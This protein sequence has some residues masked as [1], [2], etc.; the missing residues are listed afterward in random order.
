ML[1]LKALEA[2]AAAPAQELKPWDPRA[3][4]DQPGAL[5]PF[6]R[7][8]AAVASD[9]G[10]PMAIRLGLPMLGAAAGPAAPFVIP[11][12]AGAG[13]AIAQKFEGTGEI[14]PGRVAAA[15]ITGAVPAARTL[16]GNIARIGGT[17]LAAKNV[18]TLL[19]RGEL[20]TSDENAAAAA[21]GVGGGGLAQLSRRM[22]APVNNPSRMDAENIFLEGRKMGLVANPA[23][24]GRSTWLQDKIAGVEAMRSGARM[25]NVNP[26]QDALRKEIG[27]PARAVEGAA[28]RNTIRPDDIAAAKA[29]AMQ[30]YDELAKSS[31][32]GAA[33]VDLMKRAR[34]EWSKLYR[35]KNA[36][37]G[38]DPE[39]DDR[40]AVARQEKEAAEDM[41]EQVANQV[42]PDLYGR[43]VEGRKLYAKI[44][45]IEESLGIGDRLVNPGDLQAQYHQ[46]WTGASEQVAKFKQAFP[47]A[48]AEPARITSPQQNRLMAYSMAQSLAH[49]SPAGAASAAVPMMGD[50]IRNRA[51]SAAAQDKMAEQILADRMTRYITDLRSDAVRRALLNAAN[52][53]P[54]PGN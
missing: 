26:V 28:T 4:P 39:L 10:A 22:V 19:D 53:Q 35:Q 9:E 50:F 17:N 13:E 15:T 23:D 36:A 29:T 21:M 49:G 12:L 27:L 41:V 20:A 30:P 46:G 3:R 54:V 42:S 52:N 37:Q 2:K 31:P 38:A 44:V 1:E 34:A 11:A 51:L 7:I 6:A 14:S 16:P 32:D 33:A 48:M 24:L 45:P 25:A 40:L 43:V 18:E 5:D 8:G 47:N